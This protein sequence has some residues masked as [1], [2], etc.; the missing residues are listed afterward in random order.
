MAVRIHLHPSYR[1]FAGGAPVVE[2]TGSTV[3]ACLVDLVDRFPALGNKIFAA[4]DR[5]LNTI[6]IYLNAQSAYPG[7]LARATRDG[8]EMHIVVMIAGG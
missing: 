8:D 4:P 1:A 2:A 6:E 5:L 3:G 7:E